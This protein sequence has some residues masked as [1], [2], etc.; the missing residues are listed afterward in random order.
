[1]SGRIL[2]TPRSLT[3]DGHPALQRLAEAG[4][5]PVF[6]TPGRQPDEA[7]LLE[8]L[9]GCVGYL[10]GVE[11]ITARV[12]EA[13]PGLRVISR[14]GVGVSN[15]DLAAARRL[16]IAVCTTPGANA[17]GVAELAIAMMLALARRLAWSDARLKRGT[18]AR[19]EGMEIEG[20]T[21]GLVGCGAIGKQVARMAVG[22][23]MT[24]KGYDPYPDAAF[25]LAGFAYASLDDVLRSA[26]VLS[27]HCPP[28][29]DGSPAIAAAELARMKPGALLLN[30]A[31]GELLDDAAVLAALDAGTLG[32]LAVDAYRSEPPG[33]DPLVKH[34]RV[35]ATPHVGG[36]TTESVERAVSQAVANL[37]AALAP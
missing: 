37:L 27:L 33:D 13:A 31:R 26:D 3:R 10:A 15:I 36:Y 8:R 11:P 5:E 2:I 30:T 35:L 34:E 20:K 25:A 16:G 6:A 14:N 18:W 24:V 4:Y 19:A 7:E 12:L 21:L 17:R 1:M 22:L 23:G 28:P 9:P 32:G 29:A